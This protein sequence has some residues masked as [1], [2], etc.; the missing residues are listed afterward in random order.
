MFSSQ[1]LSHHFLQLPSSSLPTT[2]R[3]T[4]SNSSSI[5]N[6]IENL[7]GYPTQEEEEKSP[8]I[9]SLS[10]Q[11]LHFLLVHAMKSNSSLF[12]LSEKLKSSIFIFLLISSPVIFFTMSI[13]SCYGKHAIKIFDSYCSGP[14]NQ[15]FKAP[16]SFSRLPQTSLPQSTTH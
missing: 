13:A 2:V 10:L 7:N 9:L 3:S 15:P 14:S 16:S 11:S 1:W 4:Q 5:F 12:H 6:L 8:H